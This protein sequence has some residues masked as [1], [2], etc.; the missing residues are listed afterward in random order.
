MKRLYTCYLSTK[1]NKKKRNIFA[2]GRKIQFIDG[3][4][5]GVAEYP[6]QELLKRGI[7]HKIIPEFEEPVIVEDVVVQPDFVEVSVTEEEEVTEE[8]VEESVEEIVEEVVEENLAEQ[9][10][11]IE[12]VEGNPETSDGLLSRSDVQEM[13]DRLG[14]WTAVAEELDVSTTTLRRY[15]EELGL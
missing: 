13:Y 1:Y 10:I 12:P 11:E 14:T 6:S 8:V 15:R 3:V 2:F 5:T 9:T 4:A 7:V